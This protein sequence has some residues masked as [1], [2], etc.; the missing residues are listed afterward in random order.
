M[1]LVTAQTSYLGEH[2]SIVVYGLIVVLTGAT[3]L[4]LPTVL[5]PRKEIAGKG[6]PYECGVPLLG[7]TRQRFSIRFYLVA[8]LFVLF[9]IETVFLIPWAITYQELLVKPGM[10]WI[11]IAEMFLFIGILFTGYIYAWKRGGLDWD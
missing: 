1:N 9:D 8:I 5:A 10:G 2:L 6:L 4:I 11:V 3:M 7:E